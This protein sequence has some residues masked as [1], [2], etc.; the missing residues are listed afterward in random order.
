MTE[1]N[2]AFSKNLKQF[3]EKRNL[4]LDNVATLTGVSKS[5]LARI[6]KGSASPTIN[7]VWKI[8]NGLKISFTELMVEPEKDFEIKTKKS[9]SILMEDDGHYRNTPIFPFNEKRGFEIYRIDL[10]PGAFLQ[11]EPHPI[12]TC[13]LYTSDA[14]DD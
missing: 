1:I 11:A 2:R 12:G 4:S 8:A 3:R 5:M 13:L 9:L 10:D 7:T 14:A 6:E